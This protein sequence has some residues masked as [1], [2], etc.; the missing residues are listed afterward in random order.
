MDGEDDHKDDH[1][2]NEEDHG[3]DN[4]NNEDDHG[5]NNINNEDDHGD[6]LRVSLILMSRVGGGWWC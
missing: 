3:N 4:N 1:D 6:D 2:N 5:N